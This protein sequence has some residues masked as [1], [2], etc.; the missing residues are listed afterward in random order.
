VGFE[1]YPKSVGL[2]EREENG[3]PTNIH[4]EHAGFELYIKPNNSRLETM[5]P[6]ASYLPSEGEDARD[7]ALLQIPYTYSVYFREDDKIEWS[8]RWD[9]YFSDQVD[10]SM[11][12]WL[13]ILNSLTIS[14]VLGVTVLVIWGRTVHG[15][16]KGRGDGV[17]E[18][19]KL[20]T[21]KSS[22]TRSRSEKKPNEGLLDQAPN[23]EPDTPLSDDEEEDI[24]G[25]KLLHADVFRLPAHSSLL[26]PL[27]GS[28]TQLLFVAVGLLI[29]SCMGI[30]NPSFRGGFASVGVGLFVFAG[31]FS[32]YFSGRLYKTFRGQ[33]WKKNTLIVSVVEYRRRRLML[34][35]GRLRR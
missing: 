23:S 15:D 10:S 2:H 8:N 5:Y 33:N 9:L 26:A 31:L 27:V 1:V 29:L 30:L 19:G 3:C 13:A 32:G 35:V 12:H 11:T 20:K 24:T 22:R 6:S 14:G 16:A 7:G 28:G 4:G 25:W 17:L 18:E 34:T 21:R